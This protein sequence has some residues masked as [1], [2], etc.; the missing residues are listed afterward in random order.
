MTSDVILHSLIS[1]SDLLV[2][3]FVTLIPVCMRWDMTWTAGLCYPWYKE[4][5]RRR[6]QMMMNNVFLPEGVSHN[7][8]PQ[9]ML[10]NPDNR[11]SAN[12]HPFANL[13]LAHGRA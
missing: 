12:K 9:N 4:R 1:V 13:A 5:R 10:F 7:L 11:V 2:F 8:V 6:K 3:F